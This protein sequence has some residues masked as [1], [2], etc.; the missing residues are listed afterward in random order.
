MSFSTALRRPQCWPASFFDRQD[1]TQQ[2]ERYLAKPR[3]C[4]SHLLIII[5]FFFAIALPLLQH[6]SVAK[7]VRFTYTRAVCN[8]TSSRIIVPA[9]DVLADAVVLS[10]TM[11][12]PYDAQ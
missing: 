11:Y 6:Y 7:Q 12:V 8:P 3:Y 2:R 9:Y 5:Y 1:A 10:I 4:A